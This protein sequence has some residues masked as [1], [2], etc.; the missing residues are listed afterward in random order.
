[1]VT[2]AT[3]GNAQYIAA[4]QALTPVGSGRHLYEGVTISF[5]GIGPAQPG[6]YLWT[7]IAAT[8]NVLTEPQ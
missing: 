6:R 4:E 1:M 7:P 5:E 8:K 3:V 2:F